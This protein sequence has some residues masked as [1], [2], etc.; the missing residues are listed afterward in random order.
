VAK[1]ADRQNCV[2]F[3]I[4]Y[5]K[6]TKIYRLHFTRGII[7]QQSSLTTKAFAGIADMLDHYVQPAASFS[8]SVISG[9]PGSVR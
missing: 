5:T 6:F 3:T 2:L 4:R 9:L 1:A 8:R 7:L